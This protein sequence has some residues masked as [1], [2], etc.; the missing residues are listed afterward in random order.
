MGKNL[1]LLI[2][3]GLFL[4]GDT[5][6]YRPVEIPDGPGITSPEFKGG[7]AAFARYQKEHLKYPVKAYEEGLEGVVLVSCTI[8]ADGKVTE[9]KVSN[10][11]DSRFEDEAVRFV[12]NTAGQW[13]PAKRNGRNIAGQKFVP[14]SFRLDKTQMPEVG[15]NAGNRELVKYIIVALLVAAFLFILR[16][17]Q[18]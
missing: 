2:L 6:V 14:V 1:L 17:Q 16:K 9:V 13:I 10:S 7:S 8:E 5:D 15:T 4:L 11:P 18:K 3:I 12:E